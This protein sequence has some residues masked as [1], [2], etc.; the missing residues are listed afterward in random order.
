VDVELRSRA[1]MNVRGRLCQGRSPVE[2][3]H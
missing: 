1:H 2:L 3:Y